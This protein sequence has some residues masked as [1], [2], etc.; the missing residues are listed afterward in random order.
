[1]CFRAAFAGELHHSPR[2]RD[3]VPVYFEPLAIWFVP[4]FVAVPANVWASLQAAL[5]DVRVEGCPPGQYFR[6]NLVFIH[7]DIFLSYGVRYVLRTIYRSL[8]VLRRPAT[9]TSSVMPPVPHP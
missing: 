6:W 9:S 5:R 3:C 1:M 7:C 4:V 8:T 2:L